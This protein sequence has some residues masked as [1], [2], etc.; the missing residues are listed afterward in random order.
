MYVDKPT[1]GTAGTIIVLSILLAGIVLAIII[2]N[3]TEFKLDKLIVLPPFYLGPCLILNI[4]G[5]VLF[6]AAFGIKYTVTDKNLIISVGFI[7]R[8]VNFTAIEEVRVFNAK[9]DMVNEH[10]CP[11]FTGFI[12]IQKKK[13]TGINKIVLS[14]ANP[15]KFIEEM[16]KRLSN[17]P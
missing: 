17:N 14:P 9:T 16:N 13:K 2:Y 11:K 3:K 12:T 10:Y 5:I 7:H 6:L 1:P 4:T 15:A 8:R